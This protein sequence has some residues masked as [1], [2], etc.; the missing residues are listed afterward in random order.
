MVNR[1]ECSS[2]SPGWLGGGNS[3]FFL[4]VTSIP[5]ASAV[6]ALFGPGADHIAIVIDTTKRDTVITADCHMKIVSVNGIT[7]VIGSRLRGR[8]AAFACNCA[9]EDDSPIAQVAPSPKYAAAPAAR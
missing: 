5:I 9:A 4:G 8:L 6:I 1:G 2:H 3:S 7:P